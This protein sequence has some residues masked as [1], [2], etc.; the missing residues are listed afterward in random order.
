MVCTI[1]QALESGYSKTISTIRGIV[2]KEVLTPRASWFEVLYVLGLVA[3]SSG[4]VSAALTPPSAQGLL[5]YPGPGAQSIPETFLYAC[6]TVLGASGIYLAYLS[7][8]YST[9]PRLVN[10]YL[11]VSV[12]LLIVSVLMGMTLV[13]I[14]G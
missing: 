11:A 1:R 9:K 3:L 4:I 13:N 10:A 14:G 6:T 12:L 7:G 8:R 5:I 2:P